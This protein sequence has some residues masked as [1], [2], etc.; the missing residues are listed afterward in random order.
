MELSKKFS[1]K[2]GLGG[3]AILDMIFQSADL[4]MGYRDKNDRQGYAT[5]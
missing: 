4:K 1:E 3:I 2:N 5:R